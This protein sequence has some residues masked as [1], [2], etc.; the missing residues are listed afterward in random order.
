MKTFLKGLVQERTMLPKSKKK[1]VGVE[2]GRKGGVHW[3]GGV[4]EISDGQSGEEGGGKEEKIS[5]AQ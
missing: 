5:H 1:C 4:S 3:S 2:K